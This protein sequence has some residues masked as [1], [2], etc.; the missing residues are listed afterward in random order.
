MDTTYY[1]EWFN[2]RVEI[3]D[4]IV[5]TFKGTNAEYDAEIL[6][7]CAISALAAKIWTGDRI[8][9]FRFIQLLVDFNLNLTTISIP[10]LIEKLKK[11]NKGKEAQILEKE[12]NLEEKTK[13]LVAREVDQFEI[14]INEILPDLQIA[15][16]RKS[17]YA[18][19]I[20]S[21]LRCGLIHEYTLCENLTG[22]GMSNNKNEPSYV[23]RVEDNINK[24]LN[25]YQNKKS[26]C[27]DG[28]QSDS[29]DQMIKPVT[30]LN[31]TVK[32]LLYFPYIWLKKILIS[33][34]EEVFN[35]WDTAE[36]YKKSIP[37]HWW[38]EGQ[39][40]SKN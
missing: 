5:E 6:L 31:Y 30:L 28:S 9:R 23:N 16:I 2:G 22:Y 40:E 13:I 11:D 10:L 25:Y 8:D 29:D 12:F 34:A 35:Y 18:D 3:A 26:N 38:I 24:I 1:R 21:D 17:S 7:C 27:V 37:E 19:I 39:I 33:S 36:S 4:T 15:E 14:R 20:Y 32:K